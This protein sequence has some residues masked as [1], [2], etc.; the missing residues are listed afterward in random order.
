MIYLLYL[1]TF[2]LLSYKFDIKKKGGRRKQWERIAILMLILLSGLRNHVGGDTANYIRY[3]NEAPDIRNFWQYQITHTQNIQV[4][5]H[6]FLS[7]VKTFGGNFTCVQILHSILVNCLI[8][9]FIKHSTDKPFVVLTIFVCVS[10]WN[11]N[12][13]IMRESTCVAIFLNACLYLKEGNVWKYVL[14]VVPAL[15][16]HYFS[17][18]PFFLVLLTTFANKRQIILAL[19]G[20]A[21]IAIILSNQL[22]DFFL[23]MAISTTDGEN[24][25]VLE[26]YFSGE[27]Y[28]QTNL[29]IFGII[30]HLIILSLPIVLT[31]KLYKEEDHVF[32]QMLCLYIMF[33]ALFIEYPVF[34]RYLNYFVLFLI[35][36]SVNSIALCHNTQKLK[37]FI[38]IM[39]VYQAYTGIHEF[40]SVNTNYMQNTQY[41]IRYFPYKSIFEEVDAKRESNY[42]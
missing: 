31:I 17:F 39:L 1:V 38:T 32:F 16:I 3:F 15:F 23:Q 13:E 36:H 14:Y 18:V 19:V 7:V 40:Y 5:W 27:L 25:K 6:L 42:Y 29:N 34:S 9:R 35:V 24:S 33:Y 20:F 21:A 10:W 12:F 4:L 30:K 8:Y 28:G 26:S 41:D 2:L 22:S 11:F 37:Y